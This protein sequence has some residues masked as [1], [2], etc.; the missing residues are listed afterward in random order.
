[1]LRI[2]EGYSGGIEVV[3]RG[4]AELYDKCK[5]IT[6]AWAFRPTT[7]DE[8]KD[9]FSSTWFDPEEFAIALLDSGKVTGFA[10]AWETS[11][12]NRVSICIDPYLPKYV[13]DNT[14]KALLSWARYSFEKR[15]I[16][17]SIYIN[18]WH[19]YSYF[20]ELLKEVMN[21]IPYIER[22]WG[23]LMI[24][25]GLGTEVKIPIGYRIR[26]GTSSDIPRIVEIFNKAFSIYDWFYPWTLE[27]A[28]RYFEKHKPI[29]FVA[30][31]SSG[32]VVAF[33]DGEI[34][35]ALDGRE[36]AIIGTLA[37]DPSH[38]RRGLG[39]ALIYTIVRELRSR[40]ATRI[41][42]DGVEG[43]EPLYRKLG[44]VEYRRWIRLLTTISALP[45]TLIQY[46]K[47]R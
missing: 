26:Y 31:D 37:V 40:G 2:V 47:Y 16:S 15:S 38:Q 25:R 45:Q 30:E 12:A 41:Y 8:I 36:T 24:Y 33:V 18:A 28:K 3:D 27:D 1:M 21:G 42:L 34:F 10:W 39:K 5:S 46:E 43:L 14:I 32:E 22:Y 11:R 19:H 6:T 44:F 13:I 29:V 4:L 17:G 23:T 35:K 7:V 9:M 20:H